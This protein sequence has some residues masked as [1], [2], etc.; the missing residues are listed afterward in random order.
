MKDIKSHPAKDHDR[1][2]LRDDF[3]FLRDDFEG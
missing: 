2:I 3:S 1:L